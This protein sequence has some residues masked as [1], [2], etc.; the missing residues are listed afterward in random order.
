MGL[1]VT[2][3]VQWPPGETPVPQLFAWL[4]S[5]A[6]FPVILMLATLSVKW[7]VFVTVTIWWALLVPIT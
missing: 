4:K 3:I 7:P 6:F 2:L 1:K 5:A